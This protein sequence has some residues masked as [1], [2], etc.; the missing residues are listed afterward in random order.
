MSSSGEA[1]DFLRFGLTLTDPLQIPFPNPPMTV[2]ASDGRTLTTQLGQVATFNPGWEG[3]TSVTFDI[4]GGTNILGVIAIDDI[5][6]GPSQP[7]GTATFNG[8]STVK[9]LASHCTTE[10]QRDNPVAI[11]L[12]P[13]EP[14][15]GTWTMD[16]LI[17]GTS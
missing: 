12:T 13:T 9:L 10:I 15:Q 11:D 16:L 2:T 17:D 7:N 14:F 3:V 6:I 4:I 1:F 5:V 8:T